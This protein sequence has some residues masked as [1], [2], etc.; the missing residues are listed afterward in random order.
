MDE[1]QIRTKIQQKLTAGT[2]PREAS[3]SPIVGGSGGSGQPC[4]ACA[5]PITPAAV[6]PIGYQYVAGRYWFHKRCCE[7]WD[8]E[9]V[10][11]T[12]AN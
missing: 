1:K 6:T 4:S 5:E 8:E 7:L 11:I 12:K 2:L 3:S 10:R 9:R